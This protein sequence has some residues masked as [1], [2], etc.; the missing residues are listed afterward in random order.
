V[1][2]RPDRDQVIARTGQIPLYQRDHPPPG[3]AV[4]SRAPSLLLRPSTSARSRPAVASQSLTPSLRCERCPETGVNNVLNL[5][6]TRRATVGW[7]S[8]PS[9]ACRHPCPFPKPVDLRFA[10]GWASRIR[11][12]G[13]SRRSSGGRGPRCATAW[14]RCDYGHPAQPRSDIQPRA[15]RGIIPRGGAAP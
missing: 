6:I 12:L 4:P 14:P 10:A 3:H 11:V 13:D 1:H 8:D 5:D 7:D 2:R 9:L 15:L